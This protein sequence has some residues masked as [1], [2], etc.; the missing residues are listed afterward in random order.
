MKNIIMCLL[1]FVWGYCLNAGAVSPAL[2]D[3]SFIHLFELSSANLNYSSVIPEDSIICL[4]DDI[5]LKAGYG[6]AYAQ[7]DYDNL[8][9]VEQIAVNSLCLKGD[10][11]LAINRAQQLYEEAKKKK[12]QLGMVLALQAIGDTYMHS[13]QNEQAL[14]TF[15]EA[16]SK[17]ANLGSDGMKARLFLQLVHVCKNLGDMKQMKVYLD[18]VE[19]LLNDSNEIKGRGHY[20]FYTLCYETLYYIGMGNAEQAQHNLTQISQEASLD[21]SYLRWYYNVAFHYFT[22]VS[23][24]EHALAYCD[25]T[26]GETRTGKNL[27]EYRNAMVDKAL[28]LEKIGDKEKACQ[29]YEEITE[30][31]DSLN[32]QRYMRQIDSL[33]VTFLADQLAVE[34]AMAHNRLLNWILMG[35]GLI[36]GSVICLFI[37]A[38]KRNNILITSR[39]KLNIVREETAASIQSKSMFLSNMS[40]ELRTPLNAIVGFSAILT[41]S[42]QIAAETRKQCGDS[43]KQNSD[44]LLKLV[45]DVMDLSGLKGENI[46]FTYK[47][48]NVVSLC[49]NVVDTVEKVKQSA[50]IL[51]FS[52]SLEQLDVFTDNGRLQQVLINLLVNATKFTKEGTI[53]LTL[54]LDEARREAVFAV[55]DTGCGIPLER[56]PYIFERFEKL[57][58]GVQGV[59]LGLSICQLIVEHVGGRIWVDPAYTCGARFVFTH[60]LGNGMKTEAI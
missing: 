27:N 25:S 54:Q 49:R 43:I 52:T 29:L 48:Y 32:I 35:C 16:V 59:G 55:E 46:Q 5:S 17:L 26:L 14:I 31:T 30:L 22:L 60:P 7:C 23:N 51:H 40:H 9:R 6:Y 20:G 45:R 37:I 58:E 8:F 50:A 19:Q 12:S 18:R 38:R 24:Y 47:T 56:Q 57:H 3:E 34:N 2:N 53:T 15:T 13:N 33:H 42:D 44:L 1:L 4:C 36:L 28:L 39:K 11:G 21:E 41:S 10:I